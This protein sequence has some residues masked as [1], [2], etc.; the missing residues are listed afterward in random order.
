MQGQY[1]F[2]QQ[3]PRFLQQQQG[4]AQRQA[5]NQLQPQQ[6][7]YVQPQ[8]TGYVQPQQTG[9][10]QPQAT[11][12]AQSQS[13]GYMAPQQTGYMQPQRTG[14][15][16]PQ[17]TG[18]AS[19]GMMRPQQTGFAMQP[20]QTGFV[21][22]SSLNN[23]PPMPSLPS[24]YQGQIQQHLG[25]PASNPS[26]NSRFSPGLSTLGGL[27][28]QP[29]GYGM[30]FSGQM[31]ALGASSQPFLNTFMPAAGVSQPSIFGTATFQPSQMQFAQQPSQ[32][33][34][35]SLQQ[36]FQQQNQQQIGQSQVKVPWKLSTEEKKSYDQIFRAWDQAGSGFIEGK[37]STEVFAQSGLGREDLMQIWSVPLGHSPAYFSLPPNLTKHPLS[38][39]VSG[40]LPMSRT[41]A[42]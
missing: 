7:G 13:S 42:S 2:L 26:H 15:V 37:M 36:T 32:F 16:Q 28:T 14:F 5:G 33:N 38:C 23:M 4:A 30:G 35:M 25:L 19:G 31:P 18:F 34:G 21:P 39:R 8:Q 6:T 3:D 20:Q 12:F 10:V 11:G 27:S 24:Q 1:S 17:M 29:T 22:S 9:F 40:A 41:G